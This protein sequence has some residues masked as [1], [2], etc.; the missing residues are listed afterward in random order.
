[1]IP[2]N[3]IEWKKILKNLSTYQLKYFNLFEN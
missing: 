2:S 3:K 1:M